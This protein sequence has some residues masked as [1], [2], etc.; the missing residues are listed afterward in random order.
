MVGAL[1][2]RFQGGDRREVGSRAID[3]ARLRDKLDQ[4]RR[5]DY[6][7]ILGVPRD[8]TPYEVREA[9]E[10]LLAE[11]DPGRFHGVSDPGLRER[12]EEVRRVVAEARNVLSDEALRS[13]Y[14]EALGTG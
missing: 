10:R 5:A 1:T 12:L 11:F 8:G 3:L 7:A 2:A 9:A 14:V 4:V 13:E 6:F